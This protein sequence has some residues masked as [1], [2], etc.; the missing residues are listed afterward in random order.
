MSSVQFKLQCLVGLSLLC[1]EYLGSSFFLKLRDCMQGKLHSD[2]GG[3]R[4]VEEKPLEKTKPQNIR[5]L[6]SLKIKFS[7]MF[8]VFSV[9][10]YICMV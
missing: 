4:D 3:A 2:V 8:T 6:Q 9:T 7:D 5:E 1:S 10:S